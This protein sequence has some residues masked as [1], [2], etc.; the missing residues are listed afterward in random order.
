MKLEKILWIIFAVFMLYWITAAAVA[1]VEEEKEKQ[2]WDDKIET[3]KYCVYYFAKGQDEETLDFV[4]RV[5]DF[6]AGQDEIYDITYTKSTVLV[7][8][9][10]ICV[11]THR[12]PEV[13]FNNTFD[14]AIVKW[15]K[16]REHHPEKIK[17][18]LRFYEKKK[19]KAEKNH[20]KVSG[21]NKACLSYWQ[22]AGI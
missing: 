2:V 6:A 18:F 13:T 20:G 1:V 4:K 7:K 5:M 11:V 10:K 16:L 9:I 17:N 22:E 12:W 8:K 19:K 3:D 14:G 21:I 15:F